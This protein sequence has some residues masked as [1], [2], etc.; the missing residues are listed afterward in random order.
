[1]LEFRDLTIEDKE[2]ADKC[3]ENFTTFGCEYC[4]GNAFI[5]RK[6][7]SHRV[8]FYKDFFLMEYV[9]DGKRGFF[10]P[11]G[12][13]NIK[14]PVNEII[15]YANPKPGEC[16]FRGVSEAG[17][18]EI[19]TAFP[20][21]FEFHS[22][23][24]TYDYVYLTTDLAEL[25]GKKYHSKRN[26]ISAFKRAYPDYHFEMI[27]ITNFEDCR[28][29]YSE[30]LEINEYKN[31]EELADE[32]TA[33]NEAFNYYFSLGLKGA[34]I[35]AGGRVVAF[36]IGE[37]LNK[38][39]FCT[40]IEKAFADVRGAYP[41]INRDFAANVLMGYKYVNREDDTGSEGLR[42]AKLSYYPELL[43]KKYSAIYKG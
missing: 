17:V 7:F 43:L 35:R 20:G 4:F 12:N 5:W 13:S 39:T 15:A 37:Q 1:M 26:F 31:P 6:V 34:L 42:K 21:K 3:L 36:T 33:I 41:I 2:R 23:R 24:D 30:W 11:I 40:H 10:Y 9:Y 18:R 8:C 19:E 16:L 32:Q 22:L 27:D 29:M 38:N 14:D 28:K 25:K